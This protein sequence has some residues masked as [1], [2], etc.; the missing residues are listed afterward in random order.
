MEIAGREVRNVRRTVQFFQKRSGDV[1]GIGHLAGLLIGAAFSNM[2][3]SN[4]AGSTTVKRA[5]LIDKDQGRLQCCHNKHTKSPYLPTRDV[6]LLSGHASYLV[7]TVIWWSQSDHGFSDGLIMTQEKSV[8][9]ERTG[10]RAEPDNCII[11]GEMTS[12]LCCQFTL[13]L[14]NSLYVNCVH[15]TRVKAIFYQYVLRAGWDGS[16]TVSRRP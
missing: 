9:G 1:R 6:S 14:L 5:R 16:T 7:I 13:R 15:Q 12:L 2:S 10:K 3:H 8:I 11:R 4:K